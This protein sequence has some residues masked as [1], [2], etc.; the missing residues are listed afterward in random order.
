MEAKKPEWLKTSLEELENIV[1]ELAKQGIAA[2]KIGLILRDQYGIPTVRV[3]GKKIYEII[4]EK[5][6]I[7]KQDDFQNINKKIEVIKA[8]LAKNR[9]DRKVKKNLMSCEARSIKLEKYYKKRMKNARG[10]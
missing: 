6:N 8:H 9:Q 3:Y 1:I 10:D 4:K 5:L 7:K 2:E